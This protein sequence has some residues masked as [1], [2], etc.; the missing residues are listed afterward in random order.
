MLSRRVC[1]MTPSATLELT[2]KVAELKQQGIDVIGFN[3]GE[4]DFDTPDYINEAA[5]QAID[6]GFSKYTPVSGIL[7][8]REVICKKFKED[9]GLDYTPRQIIVSTGGKQ[10]LVNA[11]LA[12]CDI[13]DEV[14]V[15]TP[16]WVSYIEMVKLAESTPVLVPTDEAN[17]FQ[18]DIE[19]I[20]AAVTDKTKAIILN[21]PNNPTGAVYSEEVLRE[22]ADLAVKHDFYIISD[23]IYE[24]LVYDGNRHVSVAS[25]SPEVKEKVIVINGLS[26]A[27]AMTGWRMGYAAGSEKVIK[28]MVSLQGHMTSNANSITQKAA[29]AALSGSKDSIEF[30]KKQFD[31]RRKYLVNRL[32]SMEGITCAEAKGAFYLMPNV[33][34]LFG[35]KYRGK[36]LK[37]SFDVAEFLLQE[38][39]IAL[40]PGAAFQAHDNIRISYSNSLE[41]I[42]EGMDRMEKALNV[43]E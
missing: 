9:N 27:Y 15:L 7:E 41:R 36:V 6:E 18:L 14:I 11:V 19:R 32:R 31:E 22:L 28:A 30:M 34:K 16:C 4:P 38:A 33:S 17:G 2:A 23:E 13:G 25:L 26:K 3:V 29:I 24:E 35:K 10:A 43:L 39:H 20:R 21:T 40:V 42:K 37:D 12:V 8:L 1:D 5:K